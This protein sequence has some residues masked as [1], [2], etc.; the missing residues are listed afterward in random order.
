MSCTL[1]SVTFT[2]GKHHRLPSDL[3]AAA[4]WIAWECRSEPHGAGDDTKLTAEKECPVETRSASYNSAQTAGQ[5]KSSE[6]ETVFQREEQ[7]WFCL[8]FFHMVVVLNAWK[9][10]IYFIGFF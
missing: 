3:T 2:A 5:R 8:S 1:I 7:L 4:K 10:L 9:R 6:E